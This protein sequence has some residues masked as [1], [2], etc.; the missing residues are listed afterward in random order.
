MER[1]KMGFG[2]PIGSWLRNELRPFVEEATDSHFLLQ[3]GLFDPAEIAT[4]KD[5]FFKGKEELHTRIWYLLM[6]QMWYKR[7][8]G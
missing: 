7:W 8:M 5:L 6:F 4:L 2:I 1:P 3:Q